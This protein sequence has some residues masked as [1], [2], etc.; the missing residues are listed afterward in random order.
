MAQ[1]KPFVV[2]HQRDAMEFDSLDEAV[3]G[4]QATREHY[5]QGG[6]R[7]YPFAGGIYQQVT[8]PTA[9][10]LDN[11]EEHG[12]RPDK[13][14][15][16]PYC[17]IDK[18]RDERLLGTTISLDGRVLEIGKDIGLPDL[19]YRGAETF[20]GASRQLKRLTAEASA[21]VLIRY[22]YHRGP[23]QKD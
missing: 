19:E 13:N 5:H 1:R 8:A 23:D 18:N 17:V 9:F 3:E 12:R 20:E 16:F 4:P 7:H 22:E 14:D 10:V 6:Y 21:Y 2:V 15:L 11:A